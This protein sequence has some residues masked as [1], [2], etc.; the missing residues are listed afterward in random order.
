MPLMG[1]VS[2]TNSFLF[3]MEIHNLQFFPFRIVLNFLYVMY[4]ITS[5]KCFPQHAKHNFYNMHII[6]KRFFFC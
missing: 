2:R 3:K 5:C 6:N 4:S 1:H